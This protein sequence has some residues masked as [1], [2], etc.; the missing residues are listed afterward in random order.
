[1]RLLPG[2]VDG[3]CSVCA[4]RYPEALPTTLLV[5]VWGWEHVPVPD[6]DLD[7]LPGY[8]AEWTKANPYKFA[9][10]VPGTY[11][12]TPRERMSDPRV[13]AAKRR[14]PSKSA[15]K[16]LWRNGEPIEGVLNLTCPRCRSSGAFNVAG[17]IG[18][19]TA[20]RREGFNAIL[21]P[22]RRRR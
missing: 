7:E 22:L 3:R 6:T 14:W 21:L 9:E 20:A 1:V 12:L 10:Y 8:I 18:D 2:S 19:A 13:V 17:I 11:G 5:V 16:A 4:E 15:G